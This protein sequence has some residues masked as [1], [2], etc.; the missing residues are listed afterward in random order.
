MY[1]NEHMVGQAPVL[2]PQSVLTNELHHGR[3]PV[4]FYNLSTNNNANTYDG[5]NVNLVS[6]PSMA[7]APNG[8][9]Y[10]SY[11]KLR[12][13][14][15][16]TNPT[17]R[18]FYSYNMDDV[19]L[20]KS[21]DNGATWV[22][23]YNVSNTDTLES[24]FGCIAKNIDGSV[25][26]L[27]QQNPYYGN[28]VG[29]NTVTAF[30]G[31]KNFRDNQILYAQ[32]DTG[33]VVT[34]VDYTAPVLN[35]NST[36]IY[37]SVLINN[38]INAYV[39]CPFTLTKQDL[40]N[41]YVTVFDNSVGVDTNLLQIY[42]NVNVNVPGTYFYDIIAVD[43]SGNQSGVMAL[44]DANGNLQSFASFDTVSYV[45]QVLT[46]DVTP[47]TLTL[48]GS[49]TTYLYY[50]TSYADSGVIATDDDQCTLAQLVKTYSSTVDSSTPGTYHVTWTATDAAGNTASVVRTV[51]VGREPQANFV[52][53][54]IGNAI[55][56]LT[57]SSLYSP[58]SWLWTIS[59]L[60]RTSTQR[61][62]T[63]Q[64]TQ[65]TTI[66]VCLSPKNQYNAAPYNKPVDSV[67]KTYF[68]D[69]WGNGIL[70]TTL[71]N[72]IHVYPNPSSG[73]MTLSLTDN[74]LE[75]GTVYVYDLLGNLATAPI[76]I[77]ANTSDTP[78]NLSSLEA[79]VYLVKVQSA[80]GTGV[81]K[82][83]ITK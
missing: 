58:T 41:N 1:W 8:V 32:V 76:S 10:A 37:D 68:I 42:T 57:D 54:R 52:I 7:V 56:R 5:Y 9:I 33:A 64:F 63:E 23:P 44:A 36:H 35:Y 21:Y 40:L 26:V 48:L 27:Y 74:L 53:S 70:E 43:A 16:T 25:H 11:C 28:A 46:T 13:D 19:Y 3:F 38:T 77:K 22:G 18:D 71:S 61:N 82:I 24:Y 66:T 4:P 72:S 51:I 50:N 80:Q 67:C 83:S 14:N 55:F 49:D 59:P 20:L 73:M 31:N 6:L 2:I 81:R 39:G 69:V 45:V 29:T 17:N 15:D 12:P 30:N 65:D 62:P 78:L 34:P 60:H 47:P 79:G 75:G